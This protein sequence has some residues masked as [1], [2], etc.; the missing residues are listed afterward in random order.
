MVLKGLKGIKGIKSMKIVYD[1]VG[2]GLKRYQRYNK[3]RNYRSIRRLVW[4]GYLR[5]MEI[6]GIKCV[7]VIICIIGLK[8]MEIVYHWVGDW[9]KSYKRYKRYEKYRNSSTIRCSVWNKYL[10]S[11]VLKD[12][13]GIKDI[14]GIQGIKGMRIVYD[15]VW[16]WVKSY[17]RYKV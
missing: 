6:K 1:W 15:W 17:K 4:N 14:K 10:S 3:Y 9:T 16:G 8:C 12:L 13:I 7:K 11:M 2:G 5:S